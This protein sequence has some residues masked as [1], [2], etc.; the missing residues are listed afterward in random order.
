MQGIRSTYPLPVVR[1]PA[2]IISWPQ[3]EIYATDGDAQKLLT[4]RRSPTEI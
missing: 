1:Y 2:R 4:V 3:V